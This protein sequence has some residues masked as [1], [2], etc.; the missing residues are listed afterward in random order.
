MPLGWTLLAAFV[1]WNGWSLWLFARHE[2]GLLPGGATMSLIEEGPYRRSR[3]PLY[4][5]LLALHLA[6]A[7]LVPSL[8]AVVALPVSWLRVGRT[9]VAEPAEVHAQAEVEDL[10]V[11]PVGAAAVGD[12]QVGNDPIDGHDHLSW[13]RAVGAAVGAVACAPLVAKVVLAVIFEQ[14]YDDVSTPARNGL[15]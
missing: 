8:W 1:V 4:V 6:I 3:N 7:L 10:R 2:T 9:E 5:G 12:A 14:V 15:V 11:E 13:T